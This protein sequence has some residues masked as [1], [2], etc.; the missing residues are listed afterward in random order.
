MLGK[1]T[2]KHWSTTQATIALSS[3]EAE[4]ASLVKAG[5]NLLGVKSMM[6][7]LGIRDVP[8]HLHSD[9]AAAIGIA[10]RT[11]LGKLRHLEVHLLWIQQHVRSKKFK[12][13]KVPGKENPADLLTKHLGQ[14]DMWK[15]VGAFRMRR[16]DGRAASAP[17]ILVEHLQAA[18]GMNA[19]DTRPGKTLQNLD[20]TSL[21][22]TG[23]GADSSGGAVGRVARDGVNT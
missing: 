1:H 12:L 17:A 14:E 19:C 4:Y 6:G 22:T 8:L 10:S 5:S 20:M 13:S 3:G 2:I 23:A 18:K 11:G 7:D 9:S 15:H 21:R 16:Q